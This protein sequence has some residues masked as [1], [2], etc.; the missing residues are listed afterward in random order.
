MCPCKT[1]AEQ[2][3]L[4]NVGS[5]LIHHALASR[6]YT[7]AMCVF[8]AGNLDFQMKRRISTL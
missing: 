8:F 6:I 4:S 7:E 5:Y 3:A 1:G 2:L